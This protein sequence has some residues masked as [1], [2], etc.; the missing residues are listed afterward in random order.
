MFFSG[1]VDLLFEMSVSI[2]SLEMSLKDIFLIAHHAFLFCYICPRI[3][4]FH[5]VFLEIFRIIFVTAEPQ[6]P[7]FGTFALYKD[8]ESC[9]HHTVCLE[10]K[11][12]SFRTTKA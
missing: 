2:F 12:C 4:W 1:Q 6:S 8:K 9:N 5:I 11:S 7:I 3:F 10:G